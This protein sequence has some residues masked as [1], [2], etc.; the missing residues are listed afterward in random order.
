MAGRIRFGT[1]GWRAIIADEFTFGNVA[2]CAQGVASYLLKE[3][4]AK[5]GLVVGY[6]TRFAS[7]E[8][9]E[10]VAEV[11][12]G[13]GIRTYLSAEPAPTPAVSYSI[14]QHSAAG[15]CVITASHN[16]AAWNGLKYKP[17]YA[18]SAS[19]EVIARLEEEI[20][21]A[22]VRGVSSLPLDEARDSGLIQTMVPGPA[23]RAQM[24]RLVDLDLIRRSGLNVV[25]D[26]MYGAGAGYLAQLL[27]DDVA[28]DGATRVMEIHGE[29]NPAFPGIQQP[30]P[31]AA[32]LGHLSQA[33][34]E[35]GAS[36]G[37]A[38]DGD[39]DRLGGVDENGVCLSTLQA[40]ALIAYYLL[41]WKGQRG[42]LIKSLT[43]TRMIDKLGER[44]GV[45]VIETPVGF[46]DIGT[47]MLREDALMGGEESGGYGYRGHIPERDGVLSGLLFLEYMATTGQSPSQLLQ[48][49][50]RRVG[51]HHYQRRDVT[52][53]PE[54]RQQIQA[55]LEGAKWTLLGG[56]PVVS[57]D[58]LDGRRFLLAGGA[59]LAV[60]FSGTEPLLR[61]Y[62]EAA[63]PDQVKDM[64]DDAGAHLGL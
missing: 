49:L 18:G 29:V 53:A 38:L 8:F 33:V 40:F 45:P 21:G 30:E 35:Q 31:I 23:Y 58:F 27:T 3:G 14:L 16:P 41:E 15:A 9:A 37:I 36:V 63:S 10:R 50:Y 22:E 55:E 57:S 61:I 52:F 7:R 64:I 42:A 4:I 2:L 13:N 28:E 6:D 51:E 34:V 54:R 48:Q 5:Q 19:P 59:W 26:S 17:S 62:A 44:Y 47:A 24:G 56:L 60:R 39:A 20:A 46:K 25:V 12:A 32:N 1:D 11:M 43:S